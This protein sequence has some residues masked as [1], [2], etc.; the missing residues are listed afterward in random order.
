MSQHFGRDKLG[1]DKSGLPQ[2]KHFATLYFFLFFSFP[3]WV[4]DGPRGKGLR[5]PVAN[6][7]PAACRGLAF[8]VDFTFTARHREESGT[9]LFKAS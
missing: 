3:S 5:Y 8:T 4:L 7:P 2:S 1:V 9:L 6:Q